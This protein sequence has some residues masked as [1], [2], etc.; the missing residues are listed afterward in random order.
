MGVDVDVLSQSL[1]KVL[2]G[3]PMLLDV[4]KLGVIV[5]LAVQLAYLFY[6]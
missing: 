1:N 6:P 4:F 3:D 5:C 2:W